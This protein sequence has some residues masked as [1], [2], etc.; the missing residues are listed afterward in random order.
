[1]WYPEALLL[2]LGKGKGKKGGEDVLKHALS[3]KSV[4]DVCEALIGA[5][6]IE[7][8]D[9]KHWT[10][11]GWTNAI[12]AV[13]NLVKDK[14]HYMKVWEDYSAAYH[15]PTWQSERATPPQLEMVDQINKEQGYRFRWPLL[16]RSAF[17]HSSMPLSW[18]NH[19]SYERLEFLGDALLDVAC[20][21]HLF[22]GYPDKGPQWLTEH[23]MAMVSNRFLG[24][25]CVKLGFHRHMRKN[26]SQLTKDV[27][28]YVAEIESAA[29]KVQ[30]SQEVD[31][32]MHV[33][34]PPK[35][36]EYS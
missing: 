12:T 15:V 30:Q 31:Y 17:T 16:L 7:H 5:A 33:K 21:T 36:C 27:S 4:A 26:D 23:K 19:P 35:V 2:L 28:A 29:E 11:Q 6:F 18:E 24:A 1:L 25:V 3:E 10:P 13:T 8:N 22:Y 32:W 9:P 20:I 14:N 34:D